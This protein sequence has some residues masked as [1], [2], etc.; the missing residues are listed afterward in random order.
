MED[1]SSRSRESDVGK[2]DKSD[3]SDMSDTPDMIDPA[4]TSD[5]D[6]ELL[7]GE[8]VPP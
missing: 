1:K 2:L 7:V 4:R 8:L 6:R 5:D 3:M